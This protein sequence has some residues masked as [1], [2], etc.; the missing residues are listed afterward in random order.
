MALIWFGISLGCTGLTSQ[1]VVG[2]TEVK[3]RR[4]FQDERAWAAPTGGWATEEPD[5]RKRSP[6][7]TIHMKCDTDILVS[8]VTLHFS[9]PTCAFF[10][11]FFNAFFSSKLLSRIIFISVCSGCKES[12][13]GL[14]AYSGKAHLRMHTGCR[15]DADYPAVGFDRML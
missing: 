13:R 12:M 2:V 11:F 3:G 15:A 7:T 5:T 4:S 8:N 6:I 10:F 1:V 9:R 14:Y